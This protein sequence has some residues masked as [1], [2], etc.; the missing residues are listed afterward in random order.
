MKTIL[1]IFS[2]FLFP[3]SLFGQT[4]V[5]KSDSNPLLKSINVSK[6]QLDRVRGNCWFCGGNYTFFYDSKGN[7]NKVINLMSKETNCIYDS[8]GKITSI[9]R[10]TSKDVFTYD[11]KGRIST[12]I[13]TS[14]GQDSNSF[15]IEK[16][17]YKYDTIQNIIIMYL[18]FS[19]FNIWSPTEIWTSFYKGSQ[20]EVMYGATCETEDCRDQKIEFNY[21]VNMNL[22]SKIHYLRQEPTKPWIM[23]YKDEYSYDTYM[24]LTRVTY[25][26]STSEGGDL[27]LKRKSEFKY[28]NSYSFKDLFLP[29]KYYGLYNDHY[30]YRETD[31]INH[32]RTEQ[33]DFTYDMDLVQWK[34]TGTCIYD[35]SEHTITGIEENPQKELMVYP[36]PAKDHITFVINTTNE[37]SVVELYD[38][39]CRL[40]LKEEIPQDKRIQVE[41]L[42]RGL[43]VYKLNYQSTVVTGKIVLH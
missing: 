28:D 5:S 9:T 11:L 32:K 31:F 38:S 15:Y 2:V 3:I 27:E 14:S 12:M 6:L 10:E 19:Q 40:V 24:N 39:Q 36:N 17:V 43:Y 18:S 1:L 35:Y 7:N 33:F 16:S 41:H 13:R 22:I 34:S 20:I 26:Q 30:W 37:P 25:W 42:Q 29:Y 21:D 4:D 8:I 23:M